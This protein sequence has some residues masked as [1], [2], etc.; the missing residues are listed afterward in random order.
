MREILL[1]IILLLIGALI[2]AVGQMAPKEWQWQKRLTFGIAI[3]LVAV[4]AF[5]GGYEWRNQE[6]SSTA[7]AA[8]PAII[9][10]QTLN[11]PPET[12]QPTPA[13]A[14]TATQEPSV[15]PPPSFNGIPVS[16]K[17]PN[18]SRAVIE[19]KPVI[20]DIGRLTEINQKEGD[21]ALPVM[22]PLG[23]NVSLPDPLP[24]Y[25]YSYQLP[26][27]GQEPC[28]NWPNRYNTVSMKYDLAGGV[29][30]VFAEK[31]GDYPSRLLLPI[32]DKQDIPKLGNPAACRRRGT[33]PLGGPI[34]VSTAEES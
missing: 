27:G 4:S 13:P 19:V 33:R 23:W 8:S 12:R 1:Q 5:W 10:T 30:L 32:S 28:I 9:P 3:V 17:L 7:T 22:V 26:D 14:L 25:W 24:R 15:T 34:S 2:G 16:V 20:G 29:V 11:A 18:G 21:L 6:I 31:G